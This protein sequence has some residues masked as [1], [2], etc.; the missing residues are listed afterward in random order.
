MLKSFRKKGFMITLALAFIICRAA[1]TQDAPPI[2]APDIAPQPREEV[3]A[4]LPSPGNITVNFKDV[5][6]LTVLNYLSEISGIDI[7][8]SPGVKG[9]V[10]MRLRDKPWEIALDIVTRNYGFAYSREGNIIRV[11]PRTMLQAEEPVTVVIPL[12]YIIREVELSRSGGGGGTEDPTGAESSGTSSGGGDSYS[13]SMKEKSIEQ[14][15]KA[16]T[17]IIDPGRGESATFVANANALV[18][19]SIPAKINVIKEMLVKIDKKPAQIVLEAKVIELVLDDSEKLGIDWNTVV[20]AAGARRPMT[21]PWANNG[22]FMGIDGDFQRSMYP[23][24]DTIEGRTDF[25]LFGNSATAFLVNPFNPTVGDAS[26]WTYGTLD[27]TQFTAVLRM[28]NNRTDTNIL[29]TPRITTLNNQ[30]ATIKVVQ[31]VML[32]ETQASTQTANTVT[33]QFEDDASAREIGV[34]LTVVP[35]VNEGGDITVNLVPEVSSNLAF[36]NLQVGNAG[37]NTAIAMTYDTRESNTQV[38]VK[39]GETIFIGGLIQDQKVK[40]VSKVPVLGDLFGDIPYL[41]KLVKYEGDVVDKTE[42]VFFVT[43]HMVKDGTESISKSGTV[44]HYDRYQLNKVSEEKG[45]REKK[46]KKIKMLKDKSEKKKII[47]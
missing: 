13:V 24:N 16:I 31:K 1:F 17:S 40:N 22:L 9:L 2:P 27:F 42:I 36:Q 20:T 12:N 30:K 39:D 10:T 28:I 34:K 3:S 23:R 25:P 6:I 21:Y 11:M 32:Q 33:V 7:I 43:V 38:R 46:D 4:A 35:H 5:D 44:D 47:W 26:M 19:T 18:I 8:P 14:L 41:G 37:T 15:M 29:S 45:V